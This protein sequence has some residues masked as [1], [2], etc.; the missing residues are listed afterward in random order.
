MSAPGVGWSQTEAPVEDD[1]DDDVTVP[2]P[3]DEPAAPA[4]A[5]VVGFYGSARVVV[6]SEGLGL[7]VRDKLRI[8][9]LLL[10]C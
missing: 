2:E 7:K 1:E 9:T 5:E 8:S 6:G 4:P 10:S 3:D